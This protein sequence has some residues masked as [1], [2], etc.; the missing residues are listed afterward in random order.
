M[1]SKA[2]NAFLY[3][4]KC[5]LQGTCQP[6]HWAPHSTGWGSAPAEAKSTA[7]VHKHC[8]CCCTMNCVHA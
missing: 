4:V 8:C 2:H 1:D 7:P 6:P 5:L 3:N